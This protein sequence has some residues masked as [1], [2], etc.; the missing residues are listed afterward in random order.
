MSKLKSKP[1]KRNWV[2]RTVWTGDNLQIMRGMNSES[3]DL[4]YLDPP[5]NSNRT[6]AAP[7]GSEAAGAAFKDTW[8]LD[9]VDH[10]WLGEIDEQMPALCAIIHAA[11]DSHSDGMKSYLI[12]MAVR[13]LEMKRL[14]KSTGS[15]YLHCDDTAVDYLKILMDVIFESSNSRG[16]IVWQRAAG[17]AKGSQH[18]PRT[19][20]RDV[21]YILHYSRSDA[22]LHHGIRME[23]SEVEMKTKFP[24]TDRHGR[25]YNTDVPLFRQPSMG[26]RPNLCY[27]YKGVTNPH[28]SGWRVSRK[29][30]EAMDANGEIIWRDG[31]RPLRKSFA[32]NYKGKSLGN[33]WT[34]IP[35]ITGGDEYLGYPTQKP[36]KLLGRIIRA[37]SNEGDMVLDPFCGCA[38]APVA[39]EQ[40]R[41]Q[42]VGI[43]IAAKAADLVQY[44]LNR[45]E[46]GPALCEPI[47]RDDIPQRTDQGKLPHYG[48]HLNVLFGKQGGFCAGYEKFFHKENHTVDHIVPKSKGG[49]DHLDNLQLLCAH[50]NSLKSTGTN[51]ELKAKLKR[52]KILK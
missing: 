43:D 8:T 51:I 40:L 13:L 12:M 33:L 35:N 36:L 22:Y 14:L 16:R 21:D 44:R 38:T 49:T 28:P 26:E 5:F 19:F 47:V 52:L 27:T 17:R 11:G 4:I 20:G 42:W 37:S 1:A 48:T 46:I 3:V 23:L 39:A 25:Q 50:C 32:E 30:L 45:N 15:I 18:A 7:V 31:K 29:R 34:D 24:H 9:D 10:A 41:R 6:Y 2:N